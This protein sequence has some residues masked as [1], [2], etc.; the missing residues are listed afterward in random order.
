MSIF[1]ILLIIGVAI[2]AVSLVF[3][4][5]LG[6]VGSLLNIDIDV[7]ADAS[8]GVFEVLLPVSPIVWCVQL[9]VMGCVGEMLRRSE[10]FEIVPIWIIAVIS[11]YVGM[12]IVNNG[13][14]RPLKK[15]KIYT[16]SI[17]CMLGTQAEV[18]EMIQIN[19][20][21]AVKIVGKAGSTIFAAKCVDS[22]LINQGETVRIIKIEKG[23]AT[24]EAVSTEL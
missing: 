23:V 4:A 3:S 17:N 8:G 22:A 2:P 14:M 16:D 18:I 1:M 9:I 10:N 21:G 19:G 20:T 12:L 5:L 6:S 7:D 11:G 24:V 15:A 13:I